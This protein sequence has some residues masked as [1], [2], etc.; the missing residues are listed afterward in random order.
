MFYA[1]SI[2]CHATAWLILTLGGTVFDR[3]LVQFYS[4][5]YTCQISV[6]ASN[7]C[8]PSQPGQHNVN[9]GQ[10]PGTPTISGPTD[11]CGGQGE[12]YSASASGN[13][14]SWSWTSGCGG[15]FNPQNGNPT[16]WTP[17]MG[18]TGPCQ[19]SVVASNI[20][21]IRFSLARRHPAI[22]QAGVG[23]RIV[24]AFFILRTAIQ[25]TGRLPWVIRDSVRSQWWPPIIADRPIRGNIMSMLSRDSGHPSSLDR[26]MYAEAIRF[27][28]ARRFPVIR[29][30]GVGI[31]VVEVPLILRTAIPPPGRLPWVIRDP[32]RSR[33][34]PAIFVD[35]RDPDHIWTD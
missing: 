32:V 18:Y 8:G 31:R 22:Q 20:C 17:P 1:S 33:W 9:V 25:P 15:T 28:L 27:S 24:A 11:V 10:I 6:V 14:T 23:V 2:D 29:L 30:A 21:G 4:G 13:P 12:Q 5:D 19:I 16:T 7:I 26:L 35:P 34:W 3:H